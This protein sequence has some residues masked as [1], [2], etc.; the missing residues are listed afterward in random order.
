MS[1]SKL[2]P[3]GGANDFNIAIG[4]PYSS[5]TL[6]K[7][8]SAGSYTIA[9]ATADTSFDIYAYN[10]NGTLA[11]YTKSPS[12]TVSIGF[13]K[14]VILGCQTGDLLSFT[15]KTTYSSVS[16]SDEVTAGPVVESVSPSTMPAVNDSATITG[17]NF[18]SDVTI[19]L[20]PSGGSP[21]NPKSTTRNSA[22]SITIVR[23]DTFPAGT[24]YAITATNPGITNPTGSNVHILANAVSGGQTPSWVTAA[25][26]QFMKSTAFSL[27]VSATDADGTVTYS[28]V[29]DTLPSGIT[30]TATSGV[31]AGTATVTTNGSLTVRATDNGGNFVDRV[32]TLTHYQPVISTTG[33]TLT[34]G[35]EGQTYTKTFAASDGSGIAPTWSIASG[36]LPTGLTIA[37]TS[38]IVSGT[39]TSNSDAT[40]TV[41]ASNT[42][43]LYADLVCTI[44]VIAVSANV[45]Y[46]VIAGGGSSGGDNTGGGGAGGLRSGTFQ[47]TFNTNYTVTVGAGAAGGASSGA[48]GA[49]GSNSVF[50]SITAEG[51][52]LS[53]GDGNAGGV[54]GSGGGGGRSGTAGGNASTSPSGQGFAGGAGNSNG[55]K[56]GGGGGAGGT[57]GAAPYSISNPSYGGLGGNGAQYSDLATNASAGVANYFAGGGGGGQQNS[58]AVTTPG[59]SGGGGNGGYWISGIIQGTNGTAN[60]GGGSGGAGGNVGGHNGGSGIV[61][62]KYPSTRTMTVPGGLSA[63]TYTVGSFKYTKYI[64]GTGTVTIS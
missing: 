64:S 18:A 2:L 41:R 23:P 9:S 4:S 10:E 54:G 62:F 26:Q 31:I 58:G 12:L 36:A 3:L 34:S 51:G 55:A 59:G 35:T 8:Y 45:D 28:A 14:L 30:F 38:G 52:G 27:A 11:G 44:P 22:T 48:S 20:T 49:K 17:R 57:G 32:F 47:W 19:A 13:S 61:I 53:T 46:L 63:S 37:A 21:V 43:G 39:I 25:S 42:G 50:G 60:T 56:G 33:G 6:T 15:Y 40:F 5:I 16:D 29:A 1:V 24:A 7:E